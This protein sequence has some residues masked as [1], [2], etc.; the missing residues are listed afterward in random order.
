MHSKGKDSLQ[1]NKYIEHTR[2]VSFDVKFTRQGL[3]N[4]CCMARPAGRL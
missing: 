4:A 1:T 3:E 2:L